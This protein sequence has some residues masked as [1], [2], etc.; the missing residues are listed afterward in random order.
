[1]KLIRLEGV[2]RRKGYF[3]IIGVTLGV[4]GCGTGSQEPTVEW[5][6]PSWFAV[7]R[8]ENEQYRISMESCLHSFG[9]ETITS[10]AGIPTIL[11]S[12][13]IPPGV[14]EL[15]NEALQECAEQAPDRSLRTATRL[16]E[17]AYSRMLDER[18]CVIAHGFQIPEPPSFE[19]WRETS[20]PW[21]A[22]G[23][24]GAR[25]GRDAL[26]KLNHACPQSAP[27]GIT[28]DITFG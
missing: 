10:V 19:S 26:L 9:F 2:R 14:S 13:P 16:D 27:G 5:I 28:T 3:T 7:A 24:L 23:Y 22:F 6:E 15:A 8:Q 11:I 17:A 18:N 25:P 4:L 21:T 1:L 20:T 12:N